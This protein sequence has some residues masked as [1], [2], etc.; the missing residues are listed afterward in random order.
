[1]GRSRWSPQSNYKNYTEI[2]REKEKQKAR[3]EKDKRRQSE[4]KDYEYFTKYGTYRSGDN[5]RSLKE[6]ALFRLFK[7]L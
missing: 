4:V 6:E 5:F 1:M 2:R 7:Y 3:K